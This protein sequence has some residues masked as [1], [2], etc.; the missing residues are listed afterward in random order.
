MKSESV[1]LSILSEARISAL[2]RFGIHQS[3]YYEKF[4]SAWFMDMCGSL[5][6]AHKLLLATATVKIVKLLFSAF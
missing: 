3:V 1:G 2:D 5:E 6:I 4:F